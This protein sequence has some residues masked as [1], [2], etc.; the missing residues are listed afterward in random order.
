MVK[1]LKSD[2]IHWNNRFPLDR[3][4][5]KKYNIPYLSEEHRKSTFF[6]Q[7]FEYLEDIIFERHFR[8][9]E[10]VEELEV[11][12]EEYVPMS[13]NWWKGK[14]ASKKEADDWLKTPL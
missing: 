3:R 8:A 11:E 10:N 4:W 1:K 6:S 5:R 9:L 13:G 7:L 12:N 14:Q 2:I